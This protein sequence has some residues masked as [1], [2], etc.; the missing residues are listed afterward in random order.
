MKNNEEICAV[1]RMTAASEAELVL[2]L[3]CIH[4]AM[5]AGCI[6]KKE[7]MSLIREAQSIAEERSAEILARVRALAAE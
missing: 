7:A 3:E 6:T 1:Q 4:R 2:W 5:S